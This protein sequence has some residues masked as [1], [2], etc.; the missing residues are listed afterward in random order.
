MESTID[1]KGEAKPA[2]STP[3]LPSK[4]SHLPVA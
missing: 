4:Q 1:K 2:Q 3:V